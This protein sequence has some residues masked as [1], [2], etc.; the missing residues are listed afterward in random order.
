MHKSIILGADIGGSHITVCLVDVLER[1]IINDVMVRRNV[2]SD[3]NAQEIISQWCAAI[4][5]LFENAAFK[6][7]KMGIAM[8]GPFDYERGISYIKG[9]NKYESLYGLN[10][11]ELLAAELDILP[12]CINILNDAPCF[13]QGEVFGGA[14]KGYKNVIGIT[15]GTGFGSAIYSDE[16]ARDAEF[17]QI[18]FKDSIAEHYFSTNWFLNQYQLLTGETLGSVKDLVAKFPQ[19]RTIVKN[20]FEEF[21]CNLALFLDKAITRESPELLV[22][23]GN[24]S[25]AFDFFGPSL[26]SQLKLRNNPIL[27]KTTSLGEQSALIGAASSWYAGSVVDNLI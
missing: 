5:E 23:G 6:P 3:G 27:V 8:P 15:L 1:K 4:F 17:W 2:N 14:A 12:E 20:I 26:L 10:V 18:P 25:K 22:C 24:I 19:E 11:K 7:L 9:L 21:G 16:R 13:L